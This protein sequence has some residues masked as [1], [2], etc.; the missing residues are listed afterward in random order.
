MRRDFT[1]ID[2]IV[3]GVIAAIDKNHPFEIINLGGDKVEELMDFV[4]MIEEACGKEGKKEFLPMQ[5]GDVVQTVANVSKAR[6]LL[7]YDPKTHIKE[8][9]PAFVSW[10]REYYGV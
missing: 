9:I 10:Y 3:S 8:G 4:S 1:Y 5:P 6:E 7:D 2:D